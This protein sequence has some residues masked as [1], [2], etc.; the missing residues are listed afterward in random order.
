VEARG[1]QVDWDHY[2]QWLKYQ[3]CMWLSCFGYNL[4]LAVS[5]GLNDSH[6]LRALKVCR[7]MVAAFSHSWKKKCD[8]AIAQEQK[9]LP[10]YQ[11]KLVIVTCW[12]SVYDMVENH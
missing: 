4:N 11:L 5:K 8:L 2:R 1:E 3:S 9:N 6:V 10:V 12:G 7:S